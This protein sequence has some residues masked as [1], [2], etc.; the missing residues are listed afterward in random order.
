MKKLALA[1]ALAASGAATFVVCAE[2]K[3]WTGAQGTS[4]WGTAGNWDPS[5]VPAET[6][7]VVIDAAAVEATGSRRIP[8]SLTLLSGASVAIENEIQFGNSTVMTPMIIGGTVSGKLVAAQYAGAVL[9]ISDAA[10]V[11][12]ATGN[13]GFWQNGGSYLNFVDGSSRAASFTYNSSLSGPGSDPW[14]FFCHTKGGASTDSAPCIRYNGAVINQ[15]I[16]DENFQATDNGD[17]TVTLSMKPLSPYGIKSPAHADVTSSGATISALVSKT[18]EGADVY[19]LWGLSAAATDD[20]S[21]W[22]RNAN[23]GTAVAGDTF[24]IVLSELSEEVTVYYAFAIVSGGSVVAATAV[25][26]FVPCAYS[27]VFAGAANDGLWATP[28]NWRSGAVPTSAD[29]IRIDADCTRAGNLNLQEWDVTVNGAAFT[30][31]GEITPGPRTVRGGSLTATVFVA[32]GTGKAITVRG[33]DVVATT[34]GR[35][36]AVPRGFYGDDPHFDFRSGAACSY[37]YNYDPEGDPPDFATEFNAVFVGG[38]ILVDGAALTA[39]DADRVAI[40]TNLVDH[41]VTL[42]L[43]EA[44][45]AASFEGVSTA[46]TEGLSATLSATVEIGGGKPLYLLFGTD[47]AALGETLVAA[48]ATDATTYGFPT[49]GVEGTLVYWQ[50]RLGA[51]DDPDAIFDSAEPQSFFASANGNLF[52]GAMSERASNK[53]NWSKGAVPTP[54]DLVYVVAASARR[55]TLNWDIENATVAGWVQIG[56]RVNFHGSPSDILTID[57]SATIS[58]DA[59]W[60]HDGPADA[61][62]EMVNVAVTGNL[63]LAADS[64]IQVGTGSDNGRLISRGYTRGHGPGY[65]RTAGGSFAGEGGHITNTTGFVSYGSI[66]DPLSH[67]SGG[68]GDGVNYAG[69]GVVKL[70]V[71]G[72]LTVDGAIQS[73]GFGYP[74]DSEEFIGGAGSG[75][76]INI[77]AGALAGSGR[78]DANGGSNGLYGPGS[79]GRV[80]VELTQ[81]GSS[82]EDFSGTIEAVGGSVQNAE[83][84]ALNDL[85]PAA[86]G[87]VCFRTVGATPVVRVFNEFRYA[88]NPAPWRVA[89]GE[90]IPSAT[91]LPALQDGDSIASL[92]HT[93][94]ELSGRGAVR[95]TANAQ[96]ASLTLA[97]DDGSQCVYTEGHT[98]TV[99]SLTVGGARKHGVLTAADLPGVVVGE[100]SVVVGGQGLM[101]V[102]R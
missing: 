12:T 45:V 88:N 44:T 98:L 91:H 32:G 29:T 90:A 72:T 77:T 17:G 7:D 73:R 15:D 81:A 40:T 11:D 64:T 41:S 24:S 36:A 63:V 37:T 48:E 61:P 78:I 101:I 20:L 56:G 58:G 76:S 86:A 19:A 28:G 84:A 5:G 49:N 70:V 43:K 87:T 89:T 96:V 9:T 55:T 50:F 21:A 16:Y 31:S 14:W 66:L 42:T 71:G 92:R 33:A 97:S 25:N 18:D 23:L 99:G 93:R 53:D 13:N 4:A 59:T 69:G 3:T 85:S 34:T 8:N 65:L 1:L 94:W 22:D 57:G 52:V 27:A 38:K 83:S 47:P 68:W 54:A 95:L 74:L 10:I 2:T 82:V 6:D 79:G 39:A 30:A 51:A 62:T 26:S 100:G 75:G 46:V 60:T 35:W 67:G 102:V 80:K